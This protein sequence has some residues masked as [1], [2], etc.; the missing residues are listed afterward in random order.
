M[1]EISPEELMRHTPEGSREMASHLRVGVLS[2]PGVAETCYGDEAVG[3]YFVTFSLDKAPVLQA[4]ME[5]P[6]RITLELRDPEARALLGRADLARAEL[7]PAGEADR[8]PLGEILETARGPGEDRTAVNLGL[9]SQE[10]LRAGIRLA[11]AKY[12]ALMT[13]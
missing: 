2:L 3:T 6:L 8:R 12:D 7:R 5:D 10:D 1:K 11:H 13:S 4:F 9:H